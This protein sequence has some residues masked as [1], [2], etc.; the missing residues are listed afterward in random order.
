VEEV[1]KMGVRRIGKDE[2]AS[3]RLA[4]PEAVLSK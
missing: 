3:S 1:R 4:L 2:F